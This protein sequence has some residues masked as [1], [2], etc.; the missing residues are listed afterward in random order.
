L[1]IKLAISVVLLYGIY[2]GF[3]F[4]MQR[5]VLFPRFMIETP[6]LQTDKISGIEREFVETGSGKIEVWYMPPVSESAGNPAPA[7]IFAHGNGE[8]IDFWPD[9][10]RAF[11]EFGVGVLLVEYPGYGRS[12]G[13]PSERSIT[14]AFVRAYDYLVS[15]KNVD[16]SRVIFI[17]RS[18]GSGAVCA[19]AEKRRPAAI[20]LMSAFTSIRSF[21]SKYFVPGFLM[22]DPFDNLKI[23]ASYDGPVLVIHGRHDEIIPFGHGVALSKAAQKATLITYDCGHNDCPPDPVVFWKDIYV[24]LKNSRV[25]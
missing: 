9:E 1:F 12:G 3:L 14:D 10:L 6:P 24:F 2:C 17:G 8:L 22:R 23:I 19:L 13:S 18:L 4:L 11:T 7:V 5:H 25:L 20:I 15:K 16:S 21:S